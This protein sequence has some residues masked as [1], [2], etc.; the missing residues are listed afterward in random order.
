VRGTVTL[1]ANASDDVGVERVEF[2]VDGNVVG[3]DTSSPY[4]FAWDTTGVSDG[5][6]SIV[7][8]AI[9][10]A[11]NQ[12]TS[13]THT[14]VVDN[15]APA[16]P[17]RPDLLAASD[18]G[19]SS[20]DNITKETVPRFRGQA[21]AGS[22]VSVYD[23]GQLLGV[24]KANSVGT[25]NFQ[26]TSPLSQGVHSISA[27]ATDAVGNVSAASS[28]LSITIDT[29]SPLISNPLI[30]NRP[31]TPNMCTTDR[32]PTISAT[33]TDPPAT[34]SK[35]NITFFLDGAKVTTFSYKNSKV[36]YTPKKNLSFSPPQHTVLLRVEDKAGNQASDESWSFDVKAA[37]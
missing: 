3:S 1:S 27:R 23:G 19:T 5:N 30:D 8:R 22:Q 35:S 18:T 11:G 10:Q 36:S 9:D 37:C 4:S 13:A 17:S 33:I 29:T 25:W 7:A 26:V 34:L 21:E 20:K 15:A 6:K 12:A 16:A 28:R 14:V 24:V 31:P 32:T 2:L